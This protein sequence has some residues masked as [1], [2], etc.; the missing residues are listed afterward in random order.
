MAEELHPITEL[1]H[2]YG[3]WVDDMN[4]TLCKKGI[5]G[6]SEKAKRAGKLKEEN[7]GKVVWRTQGYYSTFHGLIRGYFEQLTRE[8][9]AQNE[10]DNKIADIEMLILD[11]YKSAV[12][13][14][15][16]L[17]EH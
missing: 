2:G 17:H 1:S 9:I 15:E 10:E 8:K 5:V 3:F 16:R 7:I 4:Y 6:E 11:A 13:E 14:V 12:K